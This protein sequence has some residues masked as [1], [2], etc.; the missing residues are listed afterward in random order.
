VAG[1]GS[2]LD[3]LEKLRIPPLVRP[4]IENRTR[5][6][7]EKPVV[8]AIE[9]IRGKIFIDVGAGLGYYSA[10]LS[11]NFQTILAFEAHPQTLEMLRSTIR[12]G[13]ISNV[14]ISNH[15]VSDADGEAEFYLNS[16]RGQHSLEPRSIRAEPLHVQTVKLDSVVN[17]PV[18]LVKVDVEGAEL[19]VLR[20]A[21]DSIRD[22]KV[23]RWIVEVHSSCIGRELEK[24]IR[25]RG[26]V[27]KWLD[28][29]HV[30]AS[31]QTSQ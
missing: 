10:L 19:K 4:W 26:Y 29:R 9:Q 24:L 8:E 21:E 17:E 22:H 28:S 14:R 13:K 5:F 31:L 3:Y 7:I 11:K 23:L 15:A 1:L 2:T 27:T 12:V 25:E 18:D 20:G 6:A 16:I 30:F